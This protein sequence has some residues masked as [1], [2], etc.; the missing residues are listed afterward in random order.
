MFMQIFIH[1]MELHIRRS[2]RI[3]A[4]HVNKISEM[5]MFNCRKD[6]NEFQ[7]RQFRQLNEFKMSM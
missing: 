1:T 7:K 5:C 3:Y 6:P 4:E 2:V